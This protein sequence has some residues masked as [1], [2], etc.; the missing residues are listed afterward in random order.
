MDNFS[1]RFR[2]IAPWFISSV[3]LFF[4]WEKVQFAIHKTTE[5]I[6]AGNKNKGTEADQIVLTIVKLNAQDRKY[7]SEIRHIVVISSENHPKRHQKSPKDKVP[8]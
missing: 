2:G 3:A 1:G 7:T 5:W 4:I 8:L 6:Y